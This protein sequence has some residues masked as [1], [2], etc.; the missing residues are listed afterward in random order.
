MVCVQLVHFFVVLMSTNNIILLYMWLQ[1]SGI[2]KSI[3]AAGSFSAH[4]V[5]VGSDDP[6]ETAQP[7]ADRSVEIYNPLM[8]T[9]NRAP[10]SSANL[11]FPMNVIFL[12]Q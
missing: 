5:L 8:L 1:Q 12:N 9:R 10:P 7:P 2:P 4:P 3:V 11:T 6:P